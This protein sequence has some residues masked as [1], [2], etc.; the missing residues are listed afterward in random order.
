MR[1]NPSVL[2]AWK[3]IPTAELIGISL[4]RVHAMMCAKAQPDPS[5]AGDAGRHLAGQLKR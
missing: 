5:Q 2:A 3:G 4:D 1:S